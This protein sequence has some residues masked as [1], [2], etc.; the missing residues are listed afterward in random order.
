METIL[1]ILKALLFSITFGAFGALSLLAALYFRHRTRRFIRESVE[2]YGQVVR[3]EEREDEGST[4]Y[5]PV[6]GYTAADGVPRQFVHHTAS[7]PP[8]YTVGQRVR[9]RYHR[10]RPEDA[11]MAGRSSLY[12]VS[13]IFTVLGAVFLGIALLTPVLQLAV[14]G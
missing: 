9:I 11:R 2:A 3:L 8:S 1:Q 10:Q 5:A 7:R 4:I 12:L 14:T 13:I 6:V